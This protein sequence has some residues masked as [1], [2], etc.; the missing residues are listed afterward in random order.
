MLNTLNKMKK[1]SL[2]VTVLILIGTITYAQKLTPNS[3]IRANQ[4][5]F[6]TADLGHEN[7]SVVHKSSVYHNKLPKVSGAERGLTGE[8]TNR[9]S[10]LIAFKKTFS[11]ERIRQLVPEG[12]ITLTFYVNPS[13][14]ILEIEFMLNKTTLVT[15]TELEQLENNIKANVTFNFNHKLT[16]DGDFFVIVQA[17]RFSKILDNTLE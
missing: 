1:I 12:R 14:E 2:I 16:K 5:T 17:V 10:L 4:S 7:M 11:V 13:G 9:H 6:I 3:I 15:A 8:K